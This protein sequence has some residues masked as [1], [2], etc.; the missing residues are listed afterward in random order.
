MFDILLHYNVIICNKIAERATKQFCSTI[1]YKTE[2][3][4][5]DSLKMY[6]GL[7]FLDPGDVW[8]LF[9]LEF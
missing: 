3:K 7:V 8:D 5:S 1:V 6:F 4:V 2:T 9:A